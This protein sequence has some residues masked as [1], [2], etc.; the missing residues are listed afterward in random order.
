[1][2][3][4]RRM[5]LQQGVLAAAACATTPLLALGSKRPTGSDDQTRELPPHSS[6]SGSWQDHASAFDHL[7]RSQFAGAVGTEF[8]VIIEGSAQPIWVTL[9]AVDN[10][11]APASLNPGSFAVP[12][13]TSTAAPSTDGFVL[14]FWGSSPLPQGSHLFHH[15]ALGSFALF[16]VPGGANQQISS[17]VVNRLA[18]AVVA[19]PYAGAPGIVSVP[20]APAATSSATE[21]RPRVP[22]GNSGARRVPVRD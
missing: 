19:V 13:P 18:P 8:K 11:P 20:A 15:S 16:T 12:P 2:A 17:G 9:S 21:I 6:G 3:V 10:L 14:S 1:M 22:S 4:S 5:F 7:V